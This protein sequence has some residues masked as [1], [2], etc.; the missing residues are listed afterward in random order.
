MTDNETLLCEELLN[1]HNAL[2]KTPEGTDVETKN[3]V[4]EEDWQSELNSTGSPLGEGA[5][6]SCETGVCEHQ[7][8]KSHSKLVS[9]G[10]I[11]QPVS[12][13]NIPPSIPEAEMIA[14]SQQ[15]ASAVPLVP[16]APKSNDSV[17]VQGQ[18]LATPLG[19]HFQP[20]ALQ[21]PLF[22]GYGFSQQ[23][24]H[25]L[26]AA[27]QILSSVNPELAVAAIAS[28][29]QFSNMGIPSQAQVHPAMFF[30]QMQH[31]QMQQQIDNDLP[32]RLNHQQPNLGNI[33]FQPNQSSELAARIAALARQS[34]Q[35]N[36][37][38]EG[39]M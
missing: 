36:N 17:M 22:G 18:S 8:V 33:S 28:A 12:Q 3:A 31:Q 27:A 15:H 25:Q 13:K 34:F 5:L 26:I 19:H 2:A 6:E 1:L 11:A 39:S 20:A 35:S 23:Q 24:Q 32:S 4:S 14:T 30:P 21:P 38:K 37:H 16:S 9:I 7:E 10:S 29:R